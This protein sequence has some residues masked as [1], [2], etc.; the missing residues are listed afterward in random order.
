MN[1]MKECDNLQI[2]KE[3]DWSKSSVIICHSNCK[4]EKMKAATYTLDC[5]S[6]SIIFASL[7]QPS[8]VITNF[9]RGNVQTTTPSI[10]E[11]KFVSLY[12]VR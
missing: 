3:F 10:V 2:P 8:T 6:F 11:R 4:H 9:T 12:F 7:L 5:N 1:M